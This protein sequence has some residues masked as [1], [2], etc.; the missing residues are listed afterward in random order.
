MVTFLGNC[1]PARIIVP[2]VLNSKFLNP[3]P[4]REPSTR[5]SQLSTFVQ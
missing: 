5:A 4:F 3:L 1:Y 2:N